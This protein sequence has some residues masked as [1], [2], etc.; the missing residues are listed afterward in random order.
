MAE[1]AEETFRSRV[2]NIF[3]SL[4]ASSSESSPW[5]LTDDKVEKREW[6]RYKEDDADTN[7]AD[8]TPSLDKNVQRSAPL[9]GD[10][11]DEWNI[12]SFIGLDCTLDN[13]EE[14]D[15][16]DK[17]AEGRENV[18]DRLYMRDI[19][20]YGPYLNSHNVLPNSVLDVQ[21]DTRASRDELRIMLKEAET[22]AQKIDSYETREISIMNAE[23]PHV[24]LSEDG[25]K[26]KS[27]L[28][29]KN[30]VTIRS[31]KRVR[32]DP[33]FDDNS[34]C[35]SEEHQDSFT[36]ASFGDSFLEENVPRVPDYLMNPSKYVR[37]SFDSPSDIGE[38]SNN[39]A[40]ENFIEPIEG[41][42]SLDP[43]SVMFIPRKKTNDAD[44]IFNSSEVKEDHRDG[45]KKY[46]KQPGFAVGIAA[47]E[48]QQSE[49]RVMGDGESITDS[50][51]RSTGFRK[52]GR[53]YRTKVNSEDGSS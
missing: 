31:S 26:L 8:E 51:C 41:D 50:T 44:T 28:K 40:C 33:A 6:K 10:D 7:R 29:R 46:V 25:V 1:S 38:D 17:L 12:R 16:Y 49:F 45:H 22:T 15:E 48:A 2:D 39:R 36:G 3:G 34:E 23:E 42:A 37:Y 13:E 5:D 21:R 20:D 4:N 11:E 30:N 35:K 52:S 9:N 19:T 53:R 24:I 18:G 27:I 43:K 32:F 14:E 47:E